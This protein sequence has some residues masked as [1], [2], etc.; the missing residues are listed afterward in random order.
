MIDKNAQR[1]RVAQFE[2][3]QLAQGKTMPVLPALK[4]MTPPP[5]FKI[6]TVTVS[7]TPAYN[8]ALNKKASNYVRKAKGR[9]AEPFTNSI[10]QVINVGDSVVAISQGYNKSIKVRVA[11]YVGLRKDSQ[12][13]VTSVAVS[14]TV[15]HDK[16]VSGKGY[17]KV[18]E[19]KTS[20]LPSKRIFK[21]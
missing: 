17:V 15:T 1:A 13:C 3:E 14:G 7:S 21:S 20:S 11:T 9:L 2:M 6:T 12:G 18:T 19:V 5:A 8:G 4:P 16:Y 10:G